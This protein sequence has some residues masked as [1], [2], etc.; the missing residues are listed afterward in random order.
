MD[1]KILKE[2]MTPEHPKWNE[3]C[4]RVAGGDGSEQPPRCNGCLKNADGTLN[5][6]SYVVRA[7]KTMRMDVKHSV[8]FFESYGGVCD[9][10]VL[11]NVPD[12][13]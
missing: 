10:E 5:R 3:F 7:L 8:E 9:C 12:Q 6:K 2:I 13:A 1:K 11:F 4:Y